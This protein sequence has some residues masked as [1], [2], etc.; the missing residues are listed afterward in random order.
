MKTMSVP[1]ILYS[2]SPAEYQAKSL[3]PPTPMG[4]SGRSFG[5]LMNPSSETESPVRTFPILIPL[6]TR[7][8]LPATGALS[9]PRNCG[10]RRAMVWRRPF[11]PLDESPYRHEQVAMKRECSPTAGL[12]RAWPSALGASWPSCSLGVA[13]SRSEAH[14]I[15]CVGGGTVRDV[16]SRPRTGLTDGGRS[17]RRARCADG[18]LHLVHRRRRACLLHLAGSPC[19]SVWSLP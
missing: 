17:V 6:S 9:W 16:S 18:G 7:D 11:P 8:L 3:S 14:R 1:G 10:R 12:A 19:V 15:A 5:P 4:A 13:S 2:V